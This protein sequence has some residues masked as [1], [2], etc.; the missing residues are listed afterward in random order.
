MN[1]LILGAGGREHALAWAV[2][3]NPK[4]DRLIVA[5]GNAGI[6]APAANQAVQVPAAP[7]G[8]EWVL[9]NQTGEAIP[10]GPLPMP[11]GKAV[12]FGSDGFVSWLAWQDGKWQGLPGRS[13]GVLAYT[14]AIPAQGTVYLRRS[15]DGSPESGPVDVRYSRNGNEWQAGCGK[16]KLAGTVAEGPFVGSV[17]YDGIEL[18]HYSGM[19][20]QSAGADRWNEVNHVTDVKASESTM[21]LVLVFTG[22]FRPDEGDTAQGFRLVQRLVFPAGMDY[23]AAQTLEVK[24]LGDKPLA[25]RGLFF[26]FHGAI[27]GS[28]EGDVPADAVPRLWKAA[29][30]N[31]WF[32]EQANAFFGATAPTSSQATIR[33]WLN[34]QGGQHPDAKIEYEQEIAPGASF[35]PPEPAVVYGFAGKGTDWQSVAARVAARQALYRPTE[36]QP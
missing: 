26:R 33:F 17:S 24:D 8:T 10:A 13:Q 32:D 3:Q 15:R 34:K 27:G 1:I 12:P 19:V 16:W 28:A 20:Q 6:A 5:P 36:I 22:E 18:G 23:F 29:P 9:W 35:V 4:C 11:M 14:P 31:A 2:K 25:L 7:K 21:G 30:Q